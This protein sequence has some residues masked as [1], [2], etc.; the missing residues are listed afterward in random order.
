MHPLVR[1]LY[2]RVITVGQVYPGGL[3]LVRRRA[4]EEFF[5]NKDLT[6]EEDIL[7]AV[8]RGRWYI[9]NELVAVT[10]VKKYRA[11][12]QRYGSQAEDSVQ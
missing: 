7:R 8:A 2:R 5:K 6:S 12:R 4:K 1:D 11:M 9:K 10:Q 3:E